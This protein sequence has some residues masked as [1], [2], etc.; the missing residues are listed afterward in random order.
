MEAHEREIRALMLAGLDGDAAAHEE[1]LRKLG[2]KL[3]GYFR[4][5]LLRVGRSPA[6]AEDLVQETLIAIHVRRHT[7]DRSQLLG[8]WVY[9]IARY[10]LID[11]CRRTKHSFR[12][13]PIDDVE[14]IAYDDPGEA[15]D[16][17]MD[18]ETLLVKLPLKA[19]LALRA[20]KL[21]GL[22][23]REAAATAGSSESAIK[24]SIHRSI[25]ALSLLVGRKPS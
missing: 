13:V 3:R 11:F 7:Y 5:H 23:T 1:L 15:V 18:I 16:S 17:T 4:S 12:G 10:K 19:R 6:D 14:E 24:V 9:A 2:A 25:R 20:V 21:E 8:P 22:T